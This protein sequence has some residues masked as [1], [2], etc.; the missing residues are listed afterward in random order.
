MGARVLLISLLA[1]LLL[2]PSMPASFAQHRCEQ[3]VGRESEPVRDRAAQAAEAVFAG[4]E[5]LADLAAEEAAAN[6]RLQNDGRGMFLADGRP[7]GDAPDACGPDRSNFAFI[8]NK[9]SVF[10]TLVPGE[11]PRDYY[12]L[13]GPQPGHNVT[14]ELR[15]GLFVGANQFY[16]AAIHEWNQSV[17]WLHKSAFRVQ[18]LV[19]DACGS[20]T[21]VGRPA[22]FGRV[23]ATVSGGADQIVMVRLLGPNSPGIALSAP[24]RYDCGFGCY[25]TETVGGEAA[26]CTFQKVPGARGLFQS[27]RR[28]SDNQIGDPAHDLECEPGVLGPNFFEAA[29]KEQAKLNKALDD[30]Y[31]YL[32]GLISGGGDGLPLP[33]PIV[34]NYELAAYTGDGHA[35]RDARGAV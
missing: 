13:V 15:T 8:V 22:G 33:A 26:D 1:A 21:A 20:L 11:D 25:A 31:G 6:C 9:P 5:E 23:E 32:V 35:P 29:G 14:I 17:E 19:F 2:T 10:G 4:A 27:V 34:Y 30:P 18:L 12:D 24:M 16:G 3:F 7:A 28:S